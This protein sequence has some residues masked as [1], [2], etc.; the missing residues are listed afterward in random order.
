MV[1]LDTP[2]KKEAAPIKAIAPG[3]IQDQT[4]WSG[5]SGTNIPNQLTISCP[6]IRPYKPPINLQHN[7]T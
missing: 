6:T 7:N 4:I 2:P 1:S 5:F 3:S